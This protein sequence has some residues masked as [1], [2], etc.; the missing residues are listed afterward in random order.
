MWAFEK[1]RLFAGPVRIRDLYRK[2]VAPRL[3]AT[4]DDWDNLS[5]DFFYLNTS[6][7]AYSEWE[8]ERVKPGELTKREAV[9]HRSFD[10]CRRACQSDKSCMQYRFWNGI[11]SVSRS[12]RHGKPAKKEEDKWWEYR[13]GWMVDRIQAWIRANDDCGAMHFPLEAKP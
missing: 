13:S 3:E 12:I 1:Q 11:C 9:A 7:S 10:D 4:R 8:L 2:F 5:D 6:A